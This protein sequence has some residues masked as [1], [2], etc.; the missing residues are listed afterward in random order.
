MV[1]GVALNGGHPYY[2]MPSGHDCWPTS[3]PYS[4]LMALV[5]FATG[6]LELDGSLKL[7]GAGTL[8]GLGNLLVQ[9]AVQSV[10]GKS[11][12]PEWMEEAVLKNLGLREFHL[13]P[14]A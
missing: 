11:V 2:T 5:S 1:K 13:Y 8:S 3:P 6:H 12:W 10:G 4:F 9:H 14:R 7:C